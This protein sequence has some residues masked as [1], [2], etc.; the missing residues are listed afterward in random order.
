MYPRCGSRAEDMNRRVG[1]E[2]EFMATQE[3]GS[4]KTTAGQQYCTFVLDRLLFGIRSQEIQE[5]IACREL[6]NV[7]LAPHAVMGLV[8]LRGQVLVALDLR[9]MLEL[10]ERPADMLP[11]GL[12]VRS[13]GETL[14]LL[15]DQAGEVVEADGLNSELLPVLETLS[16]R[17]QWSLVGVCKLHSDLVHVLDI[18]QICAVEAPQ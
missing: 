14:C 6:R 16:P 5:V 15:A 8:N 17:L 4:L 7:P 12:V 18:E 11:V 2:C 9:R 1:V 10:S 3:L 13:G